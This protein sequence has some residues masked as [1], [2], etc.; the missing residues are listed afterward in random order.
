MRRVAVQL[1]ML[2]RAP[3]GCWILDDPLP[4]GPEGE[5]ALWRMNQLRG[6]TIGLQL[7]PFGLENA[8]VE[9]EFGF[10]QAR[11]IR[12]LAGTPV[13]TRLGNRAPGRRDTGQFPVELHFC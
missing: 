10:Q 11:T 9:R 12:R 4:V 7:K 1:K 5:H 8:C 6:E 3:A 13:E 2:S